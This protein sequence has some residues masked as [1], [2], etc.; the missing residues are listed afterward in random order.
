VGLAISGVVLLAGWAYGAQQLATHAA[1]KTGKTVR[2]IQPNAA[3]H[4]K[5]EP[6]Y[7]GGF[8]QRAVDFTAA[9]APADVAPDLIVWPETSVP[10]P[11]DDAPTVLQAI[12]RAAGG[13]PV[14]V[15]GNDRAEDGWR[16]TLTLL[17]PDGSRAQTYYKY[18][19]VPF[20]EY[21]P[22][23]DTLSRF[24]IHGMASRD[25]GGFSKGPG[26]KLIDLPGIGPALP[27][28]CYEL[29]FPRG[30]HGVP[31]P[32]LLLQI[33]NDAWFGNISGPYQHLAQARIRAVEQGLPLIRAANTGISAVIDPWGRI[34]AQTKLNEAAYLDAG[35]P[36]PAQATLYSRLYDWPM[37]GVLALLLIWHIFARWRVSIDRA[38]RQR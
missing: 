25:G 10:Y 37:R 1:Q 15:G 17:G 24:G 11:L 9:P 38:A 23:G 22:F 6:E 3:Q 21:I 16:N 33:T 14:I 8:L 5:W 27:L 32:N 35:L 12:S 34:T 4:L 31:R 20:G 28:I 7:I 30:I 2:L 19:L 18:H 26:P 36:A 29:I 13:Q